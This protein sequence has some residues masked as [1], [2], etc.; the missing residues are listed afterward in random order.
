MADIEAM[1]YQVRVI[2]ADSTYLCFLWWPDG[3]LDSDLEE[4]QMVVHLFGAASSQACSNFALHRTA[5]DNVEHFSK[6]VI[7]TVRNNFYVD[8]CLKSLPTEGEA[9][10][11]VSDLRALP[12]RGGFKLTKWIS[13]SRR[14]LELIPVDERAKEARTLDLS[15]DGLPVERALGVKWC[16]ES[17]TFSFHV[18]MKLKLP[19]R[20]GIL[21]VIS[22]VYDPLGL[23]APF[24]LT[25]KM[26]LQDLCRLKWGWDDPISPEDSIR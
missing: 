22:S 16:M 17:D 24:V 9:S 4:Y 2:Y 23:A 13:N 15:K 12:L 18:N 14:V 20:R 1:F 3:R 6:E 25:A 7:S 8:D 10:Q 19:M 11:L 5:E 26:L 21:S